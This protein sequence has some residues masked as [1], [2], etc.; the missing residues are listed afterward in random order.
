MMKKALRILWP[1]PVTLLIV[2]AFFPSKTP[3]QA[4]ALAVVLPL[5]DRLV[6]VSVLSKRLPPPESNEALDALVYWTNVGHTS[7][8]PIEWL[9]P[10]AD[11]I[12][13]AAAEAGASRREAVTLAS[14]AWAEG[15]FI[16]AV[17][18]FECNKGPR[19]RPEP[20]CDHGW[21]V[22]PWQMHD[23]KMIGASPLVQARRALQWMRNR[24]EAWTT[25][26][27]ARVAADAW[28]RAHP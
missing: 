2:A 16:P 10:W 13:E 3:A 21:A 4:D 23:D 12:V 14:Q 17:L 9:R 26:R 7:V 19:P 15:G 8:T 24:P 20:T 28:L 6:D 11:A 27:T 22:G 5:P 18:S 25:W 1:V